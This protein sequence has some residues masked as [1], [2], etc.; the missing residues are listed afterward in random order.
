[1]K[2]AGFVIACRVLIFLPVL[3]ESVMVSTIVRIIK[4]GLSCRYHCIKEL[5][6]M[7]VVKQH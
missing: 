4:S 1:M 3:P 2:C 6:L 5:P 7:H